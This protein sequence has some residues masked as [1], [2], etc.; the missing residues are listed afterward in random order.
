MRAVHVSPSRRTFGERVSVEP[1][2]GVQ[3]RLHAGVTVGGD[4]PAEDDRPVFL[5]GKG[6]RFP[7][8]DDAGV[9][10]PAAAPDQRAGFVVAAPHVGVGGGDR[11]PAG[12]AEQGTEHGVAVPPRCA[13][14]GDVA[15]RADQRAA[16]AV[17]EECVLAKG[18]R[19][20]PRRRAGCLVHG[21]AHCSPARH[22]SAAD[23][24]G[25]PARAALRG[26]GLRSSSRMPVAAIPLA[27]WAVVHRG[28]GA[29]DPSGGG[30][31]VGHV[32]RPASTA[33]AAPV[34]AAAT[35][36]SRPWCWEA[37]SCGSVSW[38]RVSKTPWA[39]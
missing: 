34:T 20:E 16:F 31:R 7:A 1:A 25:A 17:A 38:A 3:Y 14:P 30:R 39:P 32:V 13:H 12:P 11:V 9:G 22:Q 35:P 36:A 21:G 10:D 23:A 19:Q 8:F 26:A 27:V 2:A 18:L 6:E 28:G 29:R 33:A 37:Q 4:D 24:R 15:V 5:A